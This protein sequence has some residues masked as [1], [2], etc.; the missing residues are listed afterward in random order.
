MME[1]MTHW[2]KLNLLKNVFFFLFQLSPTDKTIIA[3]WETEMADAKEFVRRLNIVSTNKDKEVEG[4]FDKE[5]TVV[6]FHLFSF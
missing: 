1:L 3:E 2:A 6:G 4:Y 5:T